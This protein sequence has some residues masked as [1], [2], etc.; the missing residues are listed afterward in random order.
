MAEH[1]YTDE[2]P[3]ESE[4]SVGGKI[5]Q[6]YV[7]DE[8]FICTGDGYLAHGELLTEFLNLHDLEYQVQQM[9][10]G[11]FPLAAGPAYRVAG[12]G[13]YMRFDNEVT[14][15]SYSQDYNVSIDNDHIDRIRHQFPTLTFKRNNL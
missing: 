15:G 7:R 4:R 12:M 1:T 3:F 14:L 13:A 6:L 9:S 10:R 11:A 2:T 8:P 5:V